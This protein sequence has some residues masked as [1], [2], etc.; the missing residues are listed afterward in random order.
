MTPYEVMLSESQERM[1]IVVRPEDAASVQAVFDR[2]DLHSDVIGAVTDT[3]TAR[4]S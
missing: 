2:W 1:L 4:G 3:G